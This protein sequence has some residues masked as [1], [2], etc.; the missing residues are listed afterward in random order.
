[1]AIGD[2]LKAQY[3]ALANPIPPHIAALVERLEMKK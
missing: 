3:D 1:L 2:S